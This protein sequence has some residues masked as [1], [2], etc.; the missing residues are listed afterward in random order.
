M[1]GLL[2]HFSKNRLPFCVYSPSNFCIQME[3]LKNLIES[4]WE[5]RELLKEDQT[6][7]AIREVLE[8]LDKG[9]LRCAEP[10]AGG[11]QVNDLVLPHS[12]DGSNRI[13][14]FR[15]PRQDET[16]V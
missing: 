4:A 13:V 7:G 3:E 11:W 9:K 5:N 6:L 12:T 8:M 15:I 16:Q 2:T 10:V 1:V 14:S